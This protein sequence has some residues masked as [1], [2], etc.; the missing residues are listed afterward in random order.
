MREWCA[1]STTTVAASSSKYD[2]RRPEMPGSGGDEWWSQ[3]PSFGSLLVHDQLGRPVM[4]WSSE[5][6]PGNP[7]NLASD[8]GR[9]WPKNSVKLD[10]SGSFNP[11]SSPFSFV[12]VQWLTNDFQGNDMKV[13]VRKMIVIPV[14]G[15]TWTGSQLTTRVK[16][17]ETP[18]TSAISEP[19]S[20]SKNRRVL[21][22]GFL[23]NTERL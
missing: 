6:R 8:Q 2:T 20:P 22:S 11:K 9:G 18:H 21:D 3:F 7:S 14:N 17:R 23:F 5:V 16:W 1:A 19:P 10:L 13:L 12:V 4:P 15:L